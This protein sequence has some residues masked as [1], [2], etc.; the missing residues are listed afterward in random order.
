[1]TDRARITERINQILSHADEP[2]SQERPVI[3]TIGVDAFAF[4]SFSSIGTMAPEDGKELNNGFLFVSIPLDVSYPVKLI[5]LEPRPT[6]SFDTHIEE[7]LG[8]VIKAYRERGGHVWFVATDGDRYLNGFHDAFFEK[9]VRQAEEDFKILVQNL[10][11][12][13]S[14]GG[15]IPISDPLHF[16]KN[17]RGKLLDHNVVAMPLNK[18]GAWE[19]TNAESLEPI[20]NLGETLTDK[21]QIGRMRDYYVVRLF[22]FDNVVRLLRLGAVQSA[23]IL[24]PY[25]CIYAVLYA[26]N[27]SVKSRRFFTRLAYLCYRKLCHEAEKLVKM[28]VGVGYRKT[29]RVRG[30]T[31]AE[32]CY[33]RRMMNTCLG[34]GVALKHGPRCMRLDALGTHLVE[35]MIGVARTVSSDT[36]FERIVAAFANTDMRHRVAES[37]G[38]RM[39]VSK[40]INDGGAKIDTLESDG[41]RHPDKWDP[42]TIIT[43]M[44]NRYQQSNDVEC[45]KFNAFLD[46][47]QEFTDKLQMH[48]LHHPSAVANALIVE[49]NRKFQRS[50][51]ENP[52]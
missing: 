31:V 16:G 39:R 7:I 25:A 12:Y 4:R 36:S 6:G 27:I 43:M 19:G 49:R 22:T 38:V 14:N 45:P 35:N 29:Q 1:M 26:S 30:V 50:T 40:R 21:S 33:F 46:E 9:C 18:D 37:V 10:H 32:P 24:L 2:P 41:L 42:S 20:L 8:Y 47:F 52:K 44:E 23:M 5:H 17:V 11:D 3:S 51:G 48:K 28:K 34:F 13:V 15:L